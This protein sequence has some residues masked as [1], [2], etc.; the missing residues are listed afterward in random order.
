MA[1][2]QISNVCIKAG[3]QLKVLQ[4]LKGSPDQDNL[5]VKYESFIMSNIHYYLLILIF[6]GKVSL[7]KLENIQKGALKFVLDDY[8]S[9]YTDLLQKFSSMLTKSTCLS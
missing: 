6:T 4:R 3:K 8:Q 2:S 7:S 9:G 5:M 1:I